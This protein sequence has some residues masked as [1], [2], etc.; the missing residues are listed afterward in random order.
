MMGIELKDADETT[1]DGAYLLDIIEN[2]L[3]VV[4][5]ISEMDGV[6]YDELTDDRIKTMAGAFRLI[7]EAQRK[8]L[9]DVKKMGKG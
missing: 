5:T 9:E 2:Q 4:V 8:L 3:S 1:E 7:R 6:L